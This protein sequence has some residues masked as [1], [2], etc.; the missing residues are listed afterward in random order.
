MLPLNILGTA[1]SRQ[2]GSSLETLLHPSQVGNTI[3]RMQMAEGC[4][5]LIHRKIK[6]TEGEIWDGGQP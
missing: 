3:F 1:T 2:Y 5:E 6:Y 4:E